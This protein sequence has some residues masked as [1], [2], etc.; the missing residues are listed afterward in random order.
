IGDKRGA[1]GKQQLDHSVGPSLAFW[2]FQ[3]WR[4]GG[5]P[6]KMLSV[7]ERERAGPAVGGAGAR[8]APFAAIN[9]F[10]EPAR[11]IARHARGEN[12]ALPE[13]IRFGNAFKA[14]QNLS[15][16]EGPAGASVRVDAMPPENEIGKLGSRTS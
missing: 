10:V 2:R 16:S 13:I 9:R 6:G 4:W 7:P 3:S 12:R 15:E 14:G 5:E 1:A 8:P 11:L